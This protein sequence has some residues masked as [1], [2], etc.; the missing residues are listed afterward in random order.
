MRQGKEEP[1]DWE[2]KGRLRWCLAWQL[3]AGMGGEAVGWV[4]MPS[5]RRDM[6]GKVRRRSWTCD[7]IEH[8]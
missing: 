3:G 4:E 7:A 2:E 1:W 6:E 5:G 8:L